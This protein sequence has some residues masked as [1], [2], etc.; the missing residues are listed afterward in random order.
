MKISGLVDM[1]PLWALFILAGLL[2]F[3]SIEVG[4]RIGNYRRLHAEQEGKAPIGAAVGATLGLLAFL[5]AFTFGMAASRFDTRK[6]NVLLE[7]NAVGTTYLRADFLPGEARDAARSLLQEYAA[8][9]S[10]GMAAIMTPE[11]MEKSAKILNQF[12]TLSAVA[13]KGIDSEATALYIESLNEIIDADAIRVTGLRNRIP[14][15]IWLMLVIVTIFSMAS[16]GY[17]FGLSG[18]RSWITTI[19]LVI[20]FTAVIT[21]IADLDRPQSGFIQVSQQPLIDLLRQIGA[22]GP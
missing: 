5:L 16:L 20:A 18:N 14:N 3:A 13:V 11:G 10:G 15:T 21:L 9:R 8:H 19:L 17:E 7:S 1:L 12:W 4:W 22:P 6:Q 2:A